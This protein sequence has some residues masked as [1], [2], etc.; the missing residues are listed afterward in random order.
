LQEAGADAPPYMIAET[1]LVKRIAI[2][3]GDRYGVGPELVARIV[4]RWQATS[5]RPGGEACLPLVLGDRAVFERGCE[6]AG[7]VPDLRGFTDPAAA[8]RSDAPAMLHLPFAAPVGGGGR[9]SA[10]AGAEVLATLDRAAGLARRG[11]IDAIVYAPLNKQAMRD[12]GHAGGDEAHYFGRL[13]GLDNVG[14]LNQL[15]EIWTSRVTS[16]VPLSAVAG[17]I[18]EA[19]VGL[20]IERMWRFLT[21]Q[22][23]ARPTLAVAALN[24]H[25]GEGGAFGREEIDIIAPAIAAARA[26]GIEA[27]GPIP[28]DTVFPQAMKAGYAGIVTMYHDQGQIALKLLGLGRGVTFL[29]G[30][31]LPVATPGHGTAF[32]IAGKGVAIPDGLEAAVATCRAMLGG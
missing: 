24:P 7:V 11:A 5:R 29:A 31:P 1:G 25:A 22:G 12:A 26:S 20:A 21:R 16:H 13:F 10:E 28:A 14:E 19:S 17:L 30:L 8:C 15:G 2:T 6:V 32:D 27:V 3:M 23:Q 9:V 4:D 18:T